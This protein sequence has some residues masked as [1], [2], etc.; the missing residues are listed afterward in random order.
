MAFSPPY[1][2][3]SHPSIYPSTAAVVIGTV[4]VVSILQFNLLFPSGAY[5]GGGGGGGGGG[6]GGGAARL[7]DPAFSA[8]HRGPQYLSAATEGSRGGGVAGSGS[9]AYVQLL[10]AAAASQQVRRRAAGAVA[11]RQRP[12][13]PAGGPVEDGE[14]EDEEAEQQ[15]RIDQDAD[16]AAASALAAHDKYYHFQGLYVPAVP[17]PQGRYEPRRGIVVTASGRI[18]GQA[19]GAYVTAYILR[20]VLGCTLPMEVF[21]VGP[22]ETFG[23]NLHAKLRELGDVKVRKVELCRMHVAANL[24][25]FHQTQPVPLIHPRQILSLPGVLRRDDFFQD[26]LRHLHVADRRLRSYAAK[27]YAVYASSFEEVL[28]FDAGVVPFVNPADFFDDFAGYTEH[29]CVRA[30]GSTSTIVVVLE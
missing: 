12:A 22:R 4:Y 11:L 25:A 15:R 17:L 5:H 1:A 24:Q 13:R 14:E 23:A 10:Q 7:A 28:L 21:F 19:I 3:T 30:R 20:R 2:R 8:C 18:A 16:A 26:S 6:S 27:P 29:G 9:G